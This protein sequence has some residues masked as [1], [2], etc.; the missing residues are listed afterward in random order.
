MAI[1]KVLFEKIYTI[2]TLLTI[3]L[4]CRGFHGLGE[5][6]KAPSPRY[7]SHPTMMTLRTVTP[8]PNKIQKIHK[9]LDTP[10]EFR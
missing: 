6:K 5:T 10:I 4:F 3:L 7:V 8:Y 9:S 1:Y 2:L